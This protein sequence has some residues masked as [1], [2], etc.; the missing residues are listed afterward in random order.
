MTEKLFISDVYDTI[1]IVGAGAWGTALGVVAAQ[2]G[3][4]VILWARES[5]VVDSINTNHE[6]AR[7]LPGVALAPQI[8]ATADRKRLERKAAPQLLLRFFNGAGT[9][10]ASRGCFRFNLGSPESTGFLFSV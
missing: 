2:S 9:R 8:R 7:F 3:R 10:P 6:N 4:G 5:D 1:G